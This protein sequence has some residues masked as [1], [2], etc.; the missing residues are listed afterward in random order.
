MVVPKLKLCKV[1]W[2]EVGFRHEI[3]VVV[4][5]LALHVEDVLGE[6]VFSCQLHGVHEVVD[7]LV[8]V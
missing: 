2:K 8:V 3:K 6:S 4:S 1:F 7:L 5:K